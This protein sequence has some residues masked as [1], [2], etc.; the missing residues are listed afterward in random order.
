MNAVTIVG[1]SEE[2][3]SE[4]A[5]LNRAWIEQYFT[6]EPH[7]LEQ[8]EHPETHVLSV[9]GTI[10]VARRGESVVGVCAVIP[11][12]PGTFEL[13]KMAV[14]PA[15]QGRG[16]GRKLGEA[17]IAWAVRRGAAKIWLESNRRL[18][19]ALRLY[20]RLGFEEVPMGETPYARADI[21][22]EMDLTNSEEERS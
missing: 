1:Y 5:R 21:R 11:T 18:E 10:F 20:R 4:F 22:M 3:Q 2:F 15:A 7:D 19:T 17:A 9:G 6:L 8:L 12:G 16:I 14:D 13:A